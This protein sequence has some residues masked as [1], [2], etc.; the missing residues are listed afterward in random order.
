[1]RFHPNVINAHVLSQSHNYGLARCRH[2]DGVFRVAR[3]ISAPSLLDRIR[4]SWRVFTGRYDALDW[5]C[6]PEPGA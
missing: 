4:V 1:M 5:T 2:E 6:Y 3:P